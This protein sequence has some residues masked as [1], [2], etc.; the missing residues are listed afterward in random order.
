MSV[1][2]LPYPRRILPWA[3]LL[4][5]GAAIAV[6]YRY[7]RQRQDS[8]IH[9]T[10]EELSA[11]A[12]LK[13]A[14]IT[15]WREERLSDGRFLQQAPAISRDLAALFAQP[16]SPAARDQVAGWLAPMRREM[17][18]E[19]ALVFDA[20]FRLRLSLPDSPAVAISSSI[21][22]SAFTTARQSREVF[23]ADLH[24]S[25]HD[26]AIHL[27]L[28]IPVFAPAT[29][30]PE[31]A[32][33]LLAVIL[34][35]IDPRKF[36]FPMMQTWPTPSETAETLLVRRE[37]DEIVFLNDLRFQRD[38]ALTL[39]RSIH[40]PLLPAARAAQGDFAVKVGVDYRGAE[41]VSALRAVPDTPWFLIAK[42][43]LAEMYAP[44][45]RE[46]WTA[47]L[48]GALVLLAGVLITVVLWRQNAVTILQRELAS[49]HERQALADRLALVTRHA[50]DI[51][52]LLDGT[53]RIVEANDRALAIYG[54]SLAELQQLPPG[55]LRPPGAPGDYER[56]FHLISSPDGAVFETLHQRKDESFFPVEFSGRS[57][58]I[59]GQ[60]YILGV[61]RDITERK[62]VEEEIRQI[63]TTLEER[64]AQ[65]TVELEAAN[66]ELE[67]F[68]YSVSHDLRAPLRAIDGWAQVLLED[69]GP[70]LGEAGAQPIHRLRAASQRMGRLIDDLLHLS[71]AT[72]Q[73]LTRQPVAP[74]TL[75]ERVL[76]ELRAAGTPMTAAVAIGT[77]PDCQADSALLTQVFF[78]LL[79]NA[80][81]FSSG[82]TEARIEVG[83]RTEPD[84]GC[85]YFV[86][87]NG[88]GFDPRYTH[89][90]FGAFQ[91]LHSA[92]EFPGTGI[93]LAL[94]Q[95]I[96]HRHGGRIWAESTPGQGATF[97]FTVA[98]AATPPTPEGVQA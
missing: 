30:G 29:Q 26:G 8:L 78:N 9:K 21:L 59:D 53:G 82:R 5:G 81:K 80:L 13:I 76:A 16:G 62:R 69:Q 38:T 22:Q 89:K 55:G 18:Y 86:R 94:A 66:R 12:D 27:Y 87:D 40:D 28:V 58:V 95:R 14:Q 31:P 6:G 39:R 23:L 88:V 65:R 3:L 42:M 1:P 64:V 52:L 85:V 32:P 70:K 34:L 20:G 75:V 51:I 54:Y 33:P 49:A 25:D 93:G 37:G 73:P 45:R 50:N 63:N 47:G 56:D 61:L 92:Q 83:S 60:P 17:G 91:R 4:L 7:Q 72:R 35:R 90:L 15:R 98:P 24:R 19:M 11:V 97:F 41:V 96:V 71:R 48:A 67:A 68:S 57:V 10:H 36:L 43:D 46:A 79:G 74:A 2:S 77:L 44:L 84:G